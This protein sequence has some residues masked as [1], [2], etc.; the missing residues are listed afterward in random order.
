MSGFPDTLTFSDARC[1]RTTLRRAC[2]IAA[3]A[4]CPLLPLSAAP[5]VSKQKPKVE[6][7]VPPLRLEGGRSLTYERSFS[8]EREV[9][10]KRRF[11]TRVL[12]LVAGAPT[13][14]ILVRPYSV[15]TDS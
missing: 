11:W 14:H 13:F 9:K 8:S 12:D 6:I 4:A 10:L 2:A 1:L 7:E 3:L 5:K 15:V